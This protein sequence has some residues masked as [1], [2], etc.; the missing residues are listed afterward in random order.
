MSAP[1]QSDVLVGKVRR[2]EA[3]VAVLEDSVGHYGPPDPRP[4]FSVRAP[5]VSLSTQQTTLLV[6]AFFF[7]SVGLYTWSKLRKGED[8]LA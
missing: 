6:Y 4:L 2:L 7:L 8:P 1:D 3:R 5:R